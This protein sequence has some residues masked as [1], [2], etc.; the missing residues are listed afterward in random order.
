MDAPERLSIIAYQPLLPNVIKHRGMSSYSVKRVG[1]AGNRGPCGGV[2]M[3]LE[4]ADQTLTIVDGREKVYSN[5]DIVNNTPIVKEFEERGLVSVRNNWDLVPDSSIVLF[6]AHG[7]PPGFH[8][9]A[10]ERNFFVIDATCRLVN[11][12]HILAKKAESENVHIGLL[13]V[14]GHPETMGI[15][16]EVHPENITLLTKN[17]AIG[18]ELPRDKKIILLTQTTLSTTDVA[19]RERATVEEF[20]NATV[21]DRG[22]ICYAANNRQAA[23]RHMVPNID[24]LLIVGS[25]HSHNS[26][27]MRNIGD[28]Y[29]LPS[30]LADTPDQIDESWFTPEIEVVGASSGAS[31]LERYTQKMMDWFRDRGTSI[32]ELPQVVPEKIMTFTMP[33]ATLFELRKRYAA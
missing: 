12:V 28:E 18:P 13:G 9:L 5:W 33:E 3:A 21:Y 17:K 4:A 10:K 1:L 30:Y 7:V 31:V 19:E 8:D 20:P 25:Q 24:M 23:V 27:E 14:E 32:V 6:S 15:M 22:T 26:N 29:G 16:G 2:N 11:K